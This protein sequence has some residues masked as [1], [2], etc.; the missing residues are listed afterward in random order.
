[1]CENP[2]VLRC[3]CI[4][5]P[6]AIVLLLLSLAYVVGLWVEYTPIFQDVTCIK[7]GALW[8][9]LHVGTTTHGWL[10]IPAVAIEANP[11]FECINPNP[12]GV[13]VGTPDDVNVYYKKGSLLSFD[14]GDDKVGTL[15]IPT[16][17][18]NPR[19]K[20]TLNFTLSVDVT[21]DLAA[22]MLIKPLDL[23]I[24]LS[25]RLGAVVEPP[26]F[27][28]PT[29]VSGTANSLCTLEVD[30]KKGAMGSMT[31]NDVELG[32]VQ[33]TRAGQQVQEQ[34]RRLQIAIQETTVLKISMPEAA[35]EKPEAARDFACGV[36]TGLIVLGMVIFMA[37]FYWSTKRLAQRKEKCLSQLRA[38]DSGSEDSS[39]SGTEYNGPQYR[40]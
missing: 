38:S 36:L 3:L 6:F 2:K 19:D 10:H 31:C 14:R 29:S 4:F 20:A 22:H 11:T 25:I 17:N 21:G 27:G 1:M 37:T 23:L 30:V 13:V 26:L 33:V 32:Q 8:D 12:Y 7:H 28:K 16:M 18:L 15:S 9:G 5:S 40:Q 24:D 35:L 39:S 34:E